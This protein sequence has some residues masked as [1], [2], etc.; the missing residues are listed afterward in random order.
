[1]KNILKKIIP[2]KIYLKLCKWYD[3]LIY[4]KN[5]KKYKKNKL[6]HDNLLILEDNDTIEKIVEG[7]K[8]LARFGDGEFKWILNVKQ[9]SFQEYDPKMAERLKEVLL[10]NSERLL[11]GVPRAFN[12][13]KNYNHKAKSYWVN[14]LSKHGEMVFSIL[15]KNKVYANASITRPYIDLKD[16]TIAEHNFE[17]LKK[18]WD[19][20][21]VLIVEGENTKMGIGN[22]LLSNAQSITRILCPSTNAF[23]EYDRILEDVKKYDTNYLVLLCLGPTAT[24]L[25]YDLCALGYQAIDSGHMDVE[26]EWFL[27][28]AKKKQKI[29]GKAVNEAGNK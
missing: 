14:F 17:A 16:K 27:Q 23:S 2:S 8:S 7:K 13:M 20:R 25:A 19:K 11:I 12:N 6:F 5:I 22:D 9:S 29:E 18:I 4:L 1:M 26:Y 3:E 10:S 24:I 15:D 21:N 28:G